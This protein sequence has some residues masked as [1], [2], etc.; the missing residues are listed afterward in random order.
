MTEPVDLA[1]ERRKRQD[2]N[3]K[4]RPIDLLKMAVDDLERGEH[5]HATRCIIILCE[6]PEGSDRTEMIGWRCRMSRAEEVGFLE[7]W[8]AGSLRRWRGR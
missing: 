6:E 7:A 1:W 2:D 4:L 5:P 8:K 3:D